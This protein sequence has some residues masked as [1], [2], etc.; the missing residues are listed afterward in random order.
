L[1]EG[2][3]I[4]GYEIRRWKSDHP[5]NRPWSVGRFV[6]CRCPDELAPVSDRAALV[7]RWT[8]TARELVDAPANLMSPAGLSDRAVKFARLVSE[9]VDPASARLGALAALGAR[10]RA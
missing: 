8:N 9:I 2:A 6:I 7:A 4:G 5:P 3:V 10:P 1:A